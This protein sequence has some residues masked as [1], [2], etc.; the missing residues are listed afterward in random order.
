MISE[1]F[2]P[3]ARFGYRHQYCTKN[4]G[5]L[6]VSSVIVI[7]SQFPGSSNTQDLESFLFAFTTSMLKLTENKLKLQ[8]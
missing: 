4:E 3:K 7:K 8:A 1:W 2:K 5:L 6:K